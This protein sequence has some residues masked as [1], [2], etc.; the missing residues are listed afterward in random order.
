MTT[1]NLKLNN[2]A[3]FLDAE[4]YSNVEYRESPTQLIPLGKISLPSS[5][6]RKYFDPPTQ[7][8]LTESIR[9]HGILQPLIVRPIAQ[10]YELVVGERRYRSATELALFEVPALVKSLSD[11]EALSLALIENLQREDLNAFEETQSILQLLALTLEKEEEEVKS[12]FYRMNNEA[13][14]LANQNVL[15]SEEM[16]SVIEVFKAIGTMTW[17]SFVSSRLPLLKLPSDLLNELKRGQIAY[18]KAMA[19][20][21]ISDEEKRKEILAMAIAQD[22]SHRQITEKVKE[23]QASITKTPKTNITPNQRVSQLANKL[24]TQNW[25]ER[26]ELWKQLEKKLATLEKWLDENLEP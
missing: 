21:K 18:T 12:L 1:Q 20:A 7:Q 17:E 3:L 9:Q 26:P 23:W 14:G 19:I 5:Q 13:K 24:K 11:Q 6:P 22:W 10:G 8:K 25:R 4:A 15:V 16:K 2:V